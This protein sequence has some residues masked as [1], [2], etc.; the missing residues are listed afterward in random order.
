VDTV[1]RLDTPDMPQGEVR[2]IEPARTWSSEAGELRSVAP[3]PHSF[4]RRAG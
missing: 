3:K 1:R 2:H 4:G